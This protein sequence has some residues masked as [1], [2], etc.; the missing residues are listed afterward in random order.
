MHLLFAAA[1]IA[2]SVVLVVASTQTGAKT[3]TGFAVSATATATRI[4]TADHVVEGTNAPI[5]FIGGPHG[6]HYPA[7][8]VNA[9][10]LRDIALL[11]IQATGLPPVTIGSQSPPT[12]T[13]VEAL[14][15]PTELP[16][17]SPK[18]RASPSPLPLMKLQLLTNDGKVD[19]Q[20]EEGES[21]LLQMPLT[22]GD[23]GGPVYDPKTN[24]V[25]GIV[26]GLAGGY[27][28][29]RW[30]SGDGLGLSVA[31]INAFL[32]QSGPPTAPAKPSFFVAFKPAPS[33][34]I[35]AT[36]PQLASS[37]GFIQATDG[38]THDLCRSKAGA[39]IADAMIQEGLQDGDIWMVATDCSGAQYYEGDAEV[40]SDDVGYALRLLHRSFLGFIDTHRA[41]WV[42]L[43]KFGVAADPAK[44]PYLALM[45]VARNPFGQLIVANVL[46][47]GPA[48]KAGLQPDDA[49]VKID[50]RPTRALADPF[51]ARLLDQPSVTLLIDRSEREFS[52]RIDL[53][54][55]SELTAN[56]P[57][58]R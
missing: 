31:A 44:N 20:A 12:G 24:Q 35:S 11:E 42:S 55:F 18:P 56:G 17:P 2:Q 6:A 54:R 50:G 7:T 29:M 8:I 22:H 52:V 36:W 49:I 16:D 30:M 34:A 45:N 37:A 5:V 26:L 58:M 23:S 48:D 28:V 53:K 32:A 40:D 4:L 14:G 21:I 3:G 38:G 57:V 10:R 13:S 43:L 9:D 33:Q 46:R 1:S 51:I 25:V 19:G 47:G 39:P 15:Y 27:G 41:E